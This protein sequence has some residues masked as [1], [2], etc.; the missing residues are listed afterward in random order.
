M[1]KTYPFPGHTY[2]TRRALKQSEELRSL[3][4]QFEWA[5]SPASEDPASV[6]QD[7][8][9]EPEKPVNEP[10]PAEVAEVA[11]EPV[12]DE[13]AQAEPN[14][15]E[16][17]PAESPSETVSMEQY[18]AAVRA[19]N[20]SQK[21]AAEARKA[22]QL[23]V[24]KLKEEWE[25]LKPKQNAPAFESHAQPEEDFPEGFEDLLSPEYAE[26]MPET[27]RL[28]RGI[29]DR[30]LKANE[31]KYSKL[32]A[33]IAKFKQAEEDAKR[34][35]EIQSRDA[36]IQKVH[37]DYYDVVN[38]DDFK[39]WVLGDAPTVFRQIYEGT[40]PFTA[41]DGAF[42]L[43]TYKQAKLPTAPPKPVVRPQAKPT[44]AAEQGVNTRSTVTSTTPVADS[45]RED[46][47]TIDELNNLPQ[48]VAKAKNWKERE[49][50]M[51]RAETT[52]TRHNLLS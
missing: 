51:K 8:L 37:P 7:P 17:Q 31:K 40:I 2:Q 24:A 3:E 23:E 20:E 1:A 46:E 10:G 48:L 29:A 38:S 52:I 45:N 9:P 19:M 35:S 33:E 12:A 32:E 21:A 27:A 44:K 30:L 13:S 18:K 4:E 26:E 36:E 5:K 22:F 34:M 15:P 42:V 49:E 39:T 41:A 47:L 43:S 16:E 11:P 6:A 50:I 14:Q 28:I 25:S